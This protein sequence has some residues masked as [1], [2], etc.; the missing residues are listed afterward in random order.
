VHIQTG[1]ARIQN[2]QTQCGCP[3]LSAILARDDKRSA[4][5][6]AETLQG[7]YSYSRVAPW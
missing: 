1:A 5:R 3:V 4:A 2:G 7:S 6:G